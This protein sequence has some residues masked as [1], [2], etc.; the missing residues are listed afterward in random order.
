MKNSD[1]GT[2]I[3]HEQDV[4]IPNMAKP[5]N[6]LKESQNQIWSMFFDDSRGKQGAGGGVMLVSPENEK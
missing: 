1:L 4:V 6:Q 2:Y 5:T 3:I